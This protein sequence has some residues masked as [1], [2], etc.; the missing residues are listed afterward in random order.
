MTV[1]RPTYTSF[2]FIGPL[3]LVVL[4]LLVQVGVWLHY[5]VVEAID[6]EFYTDNA[7]AL[8]E[9]R[10]PTDRGLWYISYSAFLAF[11]FWL[12]GNVS[13]VVLLQFLFSGMAAIALYKVVLHLFQDRWTAFFTVLFYVLWIK[14]HQWNC[15]LYTESLF[16][17]FSLLSF[18]LLS[19]SKRDTHYALTALVIAFTLF[20]RPTGICFFLALCVFL[21][22]KGI[23]KKLFSKNMLLFVLPVML[24]VMLI[25]LNKMLDEYV[26]YFIGSYSKAELIYPN[27]SLGLRASEHLDIPSVAHEP[28]IQLVEFILYNPVYFTKISL[29]KLLLFVGNVKPYFSWMH[30]TVIVIILYPLYALAFYGYQKME[31]S[32]EKFF[33]V[34]FI[35]MQTF[36]VSMTSENWD[37]R[38]LLVILPFVFILSAAGMIRLWNIYK[39]KTGTLTDA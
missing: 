14:I 27:I 4:W 17:S 5:G 37:G 21:F 26:Y 31:N 35:L 16:I 12:G 24:F 8:L 13:T 30:N 38:F 34:S 9:G 15:Y 28:L 39:N 18:A 19:L 3:L 6:S 25:L 20:L 11:V 36:T 2:P 10:F 7:K 32:A 29:I 33:I 1:L 23:Q 22:Y